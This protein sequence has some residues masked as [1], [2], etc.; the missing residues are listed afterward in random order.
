MIFKDK[1]VFSKLFI[2]FVVTVFISLSIGFASTI[3][4]YS[5]YEDIIES[6]NFIYEISKGKSLA[7]LPDRIN[8]SQISKDAARKAV[9]NVGIY[10]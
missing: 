10:V 2:A 1:E 4:G 6:A 5:A 9:Y 3:A 8:C 7:L